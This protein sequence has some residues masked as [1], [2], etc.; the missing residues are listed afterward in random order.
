MERER[1]GCLTLYLV[2]SLFAGGLALISILELLSYQ[3]YA[4]V[5]PPWLIVI[6]GVLIAAQ[7]VCIVGIYSWKAWGVYGLAASMIVSNLFQLMLSLGNPGS[8]LVQLVVQPLVLY[9]L[10]KDKM[11]EFE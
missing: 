8:N 5:I 11:P 2:V 4:E 9:I 1:G 7:I 3:R 6:V 10:V